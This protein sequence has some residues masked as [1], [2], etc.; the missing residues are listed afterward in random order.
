MTIPPEEFPS[1]DDTFK[2]MKSGE[3]EDLTEVSLGQF[4][5]ERVDGTFTANLPSRPP[6]TG[7]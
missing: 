7:T 2:S 1:L 5:R 3:R 4:L 6:I